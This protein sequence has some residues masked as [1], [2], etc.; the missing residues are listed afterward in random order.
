MVDL[1]NPGTEQVKKVVSH[2]VTQFKSMWISDVHLGTEECR[3]S[4]LLDL[5]RLTDSESL[6]LV[7]DIIDSWEL[8][9]RWYWDQSHNEVVQAIFAK[10]NAGTRVVFIPGNHDEPFRKFIMLDLAGIQI[11]D[12]L[13]HVTA[14]GKR[15]LVSHGDRF[16]GAVR[17]A[18][19]LRCC[20]TAWAPRVLKMLQ[21]LNNWRGRTGL[22]YWSLSH[23][24]DIRSKT[25]SAYLLRFENVLTQE[26]KQKGLDGVICGHTHQPAMHQVDGV[27]YCNAGDWMEHQS[28]LVE[29]FT[30]ALQLITWHDIILQSDRNALREQRGAEDLAVSD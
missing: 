19:W 5:L 6:Y 14:Q 20:S 28:A 3:A 26:A 11:R 1:L 2:S 10:A 17:K 24:V 4:R 8:K 12:E 29:D 21:W 16:D 30:G 7:G 15:M 18:G 13:V 9:R 27:L 23:S 22:P 25:S